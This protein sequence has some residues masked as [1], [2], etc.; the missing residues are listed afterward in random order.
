MLHT[1]HRSPWLTDFAALLR[2]LSEGDEL[3][4]LQDGVTAAV[5]GN[6]YLKVCV[7]PPLRS[8]P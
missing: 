8:M 3:L 4:L 5:D 2:L 6:R 7:M 1:L